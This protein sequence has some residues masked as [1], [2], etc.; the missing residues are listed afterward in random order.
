MPF[1]FRK[2]D[3]CS[4]LL[5]T[6]HSLFR[7]NNL[8]SQSRQTLFF[9]NTRFLEVWSWSPSSQDTLKWRIHLPFDPEWYFLLMLIFRSG[10]TCANTVSVFF[11]QSS[12]VNRIGHFL[13]NL[14]IYL[15]NLFCE[16]SL[17]FWPL[18]QLRL[19]SKFSPVPCIPEILSIILIS[20]LLLLSKYLPVPCLYLFIQFLPVDVMKIEEIHLCI[21][22]VFNNSKEELS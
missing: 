15:L 8:K 12:V 7:F 20:Q 9:V 6:I 16:A 21:R 13:I 10:F 19:V 22:N 5:Y 2:C 14:S 3:C 1:V 4:A 11:F 18:S 17:F